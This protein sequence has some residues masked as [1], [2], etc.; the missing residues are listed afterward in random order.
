[1]MMNSTMKEPNVLGRK[2]MESTNYKML[3]NK[4]PFNGV[5]T[6]KLKQV[7]SE[8]QNITKHD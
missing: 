6:L 1:M 5:S 7:L 3:G 2:P 8:T 4:T